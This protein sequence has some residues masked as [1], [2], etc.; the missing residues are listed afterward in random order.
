MAQQ[1]VACSSSTGNFFKMKPK[2]LLRPI[3]IL[4][5]RFTVNGFTASEVT[6]DSSK[7]W[8]FSFSKSVNSLDEKFL[9][10]RHIF[11]MERG[12]NLSGSYKER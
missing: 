9:T 11:R 3:R 6:L 2:E 4:L 8:A 7:N 12:E 10:I 5:I 1:G